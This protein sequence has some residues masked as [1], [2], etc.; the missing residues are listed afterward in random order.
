MWLPCASVSLI[1][2]YH[3]VVILLALLCYYIMTVCNVAVLGQSC[4]NRL[5][6]YY[7]MRLLLIL[8]SCPRMPSERRSVTGCWRCPWTS[9]WSRCC[10]KTRGTP[11]KPLYWQQTRASAPCP[12]SSQVGGRNP[13]TE[14]L[15]LSCLYCIT[16]VSGTVPYL[17]QGREKSWWVSM[18]GNYWRV[19]YLR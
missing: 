17:L 11:T 1:A 14:H 8:L 12:A 5:R 10:P 19:F 3:C 2:L 6:M 13:P 7:G 4:D 15:T 16:L 18:R 9:G